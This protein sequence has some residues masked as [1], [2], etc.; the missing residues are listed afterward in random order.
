[1]IFFEGSENKKF[2][3]PVLVIIFVVFIISSW[4]DYNPIKRISEQEKEYRYWDDFALVLSK[5]EES[6]ENNFVAAELSLDNLQEEGK[7]QLKQAV[8]V[9]ETREFLENKKNN[10]S[11]EATSTD[12]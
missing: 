2:I 8:L 4:L 9:E 6:F 3:L 7:Q 10:S 12:N 5:T 1:M 11:T